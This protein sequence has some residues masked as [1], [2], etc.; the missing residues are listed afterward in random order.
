MRYARVVPGHG[1]L[2]RVGRVVLGGDVVAEEDFRQ[3]L[4]PVC[5]PTGYV[6][7]DRVLVADVLREDRP[8]LTIE[9]DHPGGPAQ[10]REEIVLTSLVV[11]EAADHSGSGEREVG[12]R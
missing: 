6:D 11:V 4:V 7:G 12:L 5:V 2:V 9:D 10:A 1:V 8:G 3:G